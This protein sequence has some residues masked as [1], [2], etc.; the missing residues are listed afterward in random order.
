MIGRYAADDPDGFGCPWCYGFR[1]AGVIDQ[2]R[3]VR[4]EADVV[5]GNGGQSRQREEA[6][7]KNKLY[8]L[9]KSH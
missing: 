2:F 9:N 3:V 5:T 1:V 8:H 6:E 4:L 7:S